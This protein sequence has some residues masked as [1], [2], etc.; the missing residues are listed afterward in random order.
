MVC[1]E[2]DSVRAN[3]RG[4]AGRLPVVTALLQHTLAV[5]EDSALTLATLSVYR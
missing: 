1:Y 4:M 2:C 5:A 3:G